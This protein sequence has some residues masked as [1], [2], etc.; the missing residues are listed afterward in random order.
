MLVDSIYQIELVLACNMQ[1]QQQAL[2]IRLDFN[3]KHR[4]TSQKLSGH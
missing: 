1:W 3:E 2:L 4:T